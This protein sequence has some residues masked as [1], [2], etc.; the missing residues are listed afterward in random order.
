MSI[1]VEVSGGVVVNVL[2][3]DDFVIVDWDAI[4]VGGNMPDLPDGY[5]Y[6]DDMVEVA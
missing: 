3:T 4:A 2:G 1:V 5:V 6:N